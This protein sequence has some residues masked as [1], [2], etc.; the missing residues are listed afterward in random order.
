[1]FSIPY[2]FS[3]ILCP[4]KADQGSTVTPT[5]QW[6]ILVDLHHCSINQRTKCD[7]C[8]AHTLALCSSPPKGWSGVLST[9]QLLFLKSRS[10]LKHTKVFKRDDTPF[11]QR[12][13]SGPASFIAP[14]L[15]SWGS[16]Y[17]CSH[18]AA[19][20]P[21]HQSWGGWSCLHLRMLCP[22]LPSLPSL[23]STRRKAEKKTNNL[24]LPK[25]SETD[26]FQGLSPQFCGFPTLAITFLIMICQW[27]FSLI[28]S[29]TAGKSM[30]RPSY[31]SHCAENSNNCISE[32]VF[33]NLF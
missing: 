28:L 8:W 10:L 19:V 2:I 32:I 16:N 12:R 24:P 4:L 3:L 31:F 27:K 15:V 23:C 1:M 20:S 17:R 7:L 29:Q 33:A 26:S 13:I 14:W 30:S 25:K 5:E 18:L 22:P 11:T 21:C 6:N 9:D